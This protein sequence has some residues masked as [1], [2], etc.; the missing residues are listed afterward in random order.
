MLRGLSQAGL[1]PINDY[2]H[3][4]E[5]AAQYGFQAVELDAALLIEQYGKAR[6]TEQL[7]RFR[8]TAGAFDLGVQW[9]ESEKQFQAD[10]LRLPARIYAQSLLGAKVCT[11]Y[12]LPS[13]DLSPAHFALKTVNRLRSCAKLLQPY[14]ISLAL[15]FVGPHHLRSR[16]KHP[17]LYTLEDTLALI[18]A[19]QMPNVGLLLDAYH[20]YTTALSWEEIRSLPPS[21]VKYVHVND[22]KPLPIEQLHDQD[23][24]YTGEGV[25]DLASFIAALRDIGYSGIIAQEVLTSEQPP[26]LEDALFRTKMGFDVL[27]A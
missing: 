17:F 25:I 13:T 14:D 26:S 22:A 24:L 18:D 7:D 16:W 2:M 12:I 9:R 15:E 11:T 6:V 27:F 10:L 3:Y 4:I 1:G 5:L 20:C 8:L 21:L 23:R 19:I